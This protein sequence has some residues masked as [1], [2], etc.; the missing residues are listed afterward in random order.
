MIKPMRAYAQP[1]LGFGLGLRPK[2]YS[3]IFSGGWKKV[4]WFEAISD[5]YMGLPTSRS[6][7]GQPLDKLLKIRE[8]RPLVLH[9]VAMSIGSVDPLNM[10]Y[11]KR[12]KILIEQVQPEWVS[13]HLCFT[14]FAG[15]YTHD[16]LPILFK[17]E[18]VEHVSNRISRVQDFLGQALV[19]ENVSSYLEFS[20]NDFSEAEFLSELHR[21]TGCKLLL[22]INNVYVS[23]VNHG[24]S[25]EN[26]LNQIPIEAVVQMHLAGHTKGPEGFLI[27]TH[28]GPVPRPVL[29][30][31]QKALTRFSP[32]GIML[33]WDTAIPTF[34]RVVKELDVFR[35]MFRQYI[36]DMGTGVENNL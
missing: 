9:G 34:S 12:L 17:P 13:D 30:L 26:Y 25:A 4:E 31:Y 7:G 23:S 36:A 24:W 3:E 14:G 15:T 10:D 11:L 21:K 1:S 33:E 28:E 19:L 32:Q 18:S 6:P 20:E 22:D 5:N 16:L 29:E 27:D 35:L 8:L 2:H